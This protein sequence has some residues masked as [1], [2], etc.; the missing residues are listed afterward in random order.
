MTTL[1][2][3]LRDRSEAFMDELE[4]RR[5][6]AA[7]RARA[8]VRDLPYAAL[9]TAVENIEQV[10][11]SARFVFDTPTRLIESVRRSPERARASF[12]AR[13]GRGRRIV[14]RVSE[15][16]AVEKVADQAKA[17][18]GKAKGLGTSLGRVFRTASEAL[19]DA[20]EATFDPQDSRP[21]ED[22]TVGELRALASER[23]IA[24]RSGMNKKQ[25]IA[26][27]RRHG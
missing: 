6:E 1:Q 22:R 25:L 17:T 13:V 3:S 26:A 9:G 24:G 15:R 11:R 14:D 20:A 10:R 27:L 5:S 19:E 2:E 7:G 23:A 21:Y 8:L 4:E 12:E 18:C 16:D